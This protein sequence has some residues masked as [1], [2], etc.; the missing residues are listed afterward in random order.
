MTSAAGILGVQ[1]TRG[2][3]AQLGVGLAVKF[4]IKICTQNNSL[5]LTTRLTNI[6]V[7]ANR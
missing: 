1:V 4:I 5:P 2:V 7:K 3:E 6:L